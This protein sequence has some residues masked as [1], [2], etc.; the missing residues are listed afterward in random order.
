MRVDTDFTSECICEEY[1]GECKL[2]DMNEDE[3]IVWG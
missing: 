2:F 1:W 3:D